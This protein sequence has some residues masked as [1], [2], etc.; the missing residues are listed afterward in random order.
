MGS[1]TFV[2]ALR[3]SLRKKWAKYGVFSPTNME[4]FSWEELPLKL[5]AK[6]K[7]KKRPTVGRRKILLW[8]VSPTYRG[9]L[10]RPTVDPIWAP[11]E[12]RI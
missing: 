12:G 8:V 5:G 10:R 7:G 6:G 4:T 1:R 11:S 9:S 2:E 3:L